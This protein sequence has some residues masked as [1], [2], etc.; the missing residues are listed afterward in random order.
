MRASDAERERIAEVLR[1]AVAEGRL[2]MEEFEERLDAAYTARTHA[3]LEPLV[4]DLPVPGTTP[5]ALSAPE[6]CG[7]GDGR[8]GGTPTSRMAVAI[9][10]G[11]QRKG[12]WTA[13]RNFTAFTL[14]GGGEI[15]LREA[16]FEDRETVIRCF[17]LMGGV[18]VIVP[19]D[20][21]THVGGIGIM[22]GFD[23]SGEA[24]GDPGAPRVTVT[25]LAIFGGVS[26]E[27]KLRKAEARRLK[28]ERRQ[29]KSERKE[30]ARAERRERKEGRRVSFEKDRPRED[31][32]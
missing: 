30:L 11:F 24:D 15:D 12:T 10:G 1:E 32:D 29:L 14:M 31:R 19:P 18:Q 13:P 8:I 3:Q 9:M 17:A 4:R 28:A 2:D 6:S 25:G 16:R 20:I 21:E 7:D 23:Q 27:R 5:G 26:V 22:G